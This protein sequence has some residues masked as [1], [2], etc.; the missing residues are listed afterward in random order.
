VKRL[1]AAGVMLALVAIALGV[2]ACGG[3][4]EATTTVAG[5][6]QTRT[7]D[8]ADAAGEEGVNT[9]E[10]IELM[11]RVR[12]TIEISFD[13]P[14]DYQ[15]HDYLSHEG[16]VSWNILTRA[17]DD[18]G[19]ITEDEYAEALTAIH[20]LEREL[21]RGLQRPE[22]DATA[23]VRHVC[24]Y[25]LGDFTESA[26]GYRFVAD[27]RVRNTGNIGVVVR[28]IATW[29]L[30]GGEPARLVK[31]I[32]VPTGRTKKVSFM[33]VATGDEIDRHQAVAPPGCRV[34]GAV[35]RTFGTTE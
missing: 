19:E 12:E 26:S 6:D 2:A 7:S 3:G 35:I 10:A 20:G 4:G 25:L 1:I 28:L 22:P 33:R 5:A 27:A 23:T 17:I 30:I 31:V 18:D 29:D 32:R 24:D 14:F 16:D 8:D 11:T 9:D 15:V 21:D 13:P 34:R